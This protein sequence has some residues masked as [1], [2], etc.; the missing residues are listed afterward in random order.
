MC[1]PRGPRDGR[2]RSG[3][4]LRKHRR[5]ALSPA[6]RCRAGILASWAIP[7]V[8]LSGSIVVGPAASSMRKRVEFPVRLDL[9]PAMRKP[10]GLEHQKRD[11]DHPD[12]DLAQE[13]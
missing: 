5:R 2:W 7:P 8:F 6:K 3:P 10:I 9:A 11:D 4:A 1:R 12:R 13:G